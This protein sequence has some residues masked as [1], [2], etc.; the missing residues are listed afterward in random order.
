M[1]DRVERYRDEASERDTAAPRRA[2]IRPLRIGRVDD[3]AERDADRFAD[4]LLSEHLWRTTSVQ[5]QSVPAAQDRLGGSTVE[6]EVAQRI[7]SARGG[8]ALPAEIRRT[9]EAQSGRDLSRVR[10]HAGQEADDLSRTLDARAFTAG[11][12]VF[13]SRSTYRPGSRAGISLLAHELGHVVQ[14]GGG[15]A[16][17]RIQRSTAF[18]PLERAGATRIQR[19]LGTSSK[20][21]KAPDPALAENRQLLA[22]REMLRK[23]ITALEKTLKK[24]QKQRNSKGKGNGKKGAA[25]SDWS[26]ISYDL[27]VAAHTRL[28]A[29]PGPQG[30]A[31]KMLGISAAFADERRRLRRVLDESQLIFDEHR[32]AMTKRAAGEIY[33]EAGRRAAD[34]AAPGTVAP[35]EKLETK[36]VFRANTANARAKEIADI[37][38]QLGLTPAEIAAIA[39]FT[40][41]D[42]R[43][44][45]PAAENSDAW[46]K[47]NYGTENDASRATRKQEGSLHTAV[48]V[49]GLL[50]MPVWKGNT[51]RGESKSVDDFNEQF[52]MVPKAGGKAVPMALQNAGG[53]ERLIEI[54]KLG[55]NY[56][57]RAKKATFHNL[58][59]VSTSRK[60]GVG[61]GF[62]Q[63]TADRPL[64]FIF[65][66]R[67]TNGRDVEGLSVNQHEQEIVTLPGAEFAIHSI[68]YVTNMT[69][70]VVEC[71]Q[72]R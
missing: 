26:T 17:P 4:G 69:A 31:G 7:R 14:Q 12:D 33:M 8:Q 27:T 25:A 41:N 11:S 2:S 44:M 34:P 21:K 49:S 20:S 46:M 53:L 19:R 58:R 62:G 37:G 61:G 50:K 18:R 3:W 43:Y 56:G 10:I 52:E 6:P 57:F 32:V 24:L 55:E 54:K 29:M 47:G 23:E 45:N 15:V 38:K 13:F 35:L 65:K 64:R 39:T 30:K 66:Y 71:R 28:D 67:I 48:G 42:Y 40:G 9:A 5:R 59:I 68:E 51:T 70:F 36:E 60:Q 1:F 72:V 16:A 63:T 22:E